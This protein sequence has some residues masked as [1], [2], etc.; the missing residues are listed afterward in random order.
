MDRT[1]GYPHAKESSWIL[2][3]HHGQKPNLKWIRDVNARSKIVKQKKTWDKTFTTFDWT[4][5]S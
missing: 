2:I 5:V 1:T 4:V 3:Y